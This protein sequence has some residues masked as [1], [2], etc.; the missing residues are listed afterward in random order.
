MRLLI[1]Y[2]TL[3]FFHRYILISWGIYDI[4]VNAMPD[5]TDEMEKT[6]EAQRS[7]LLKLKKRLAIME[8]KVTSMVTIFQVFQ[9]V[10]GLLIILI[11]LYFILTNI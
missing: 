1:L 4:K 9:I 2:K 6:L 11:L 7:N 5:D 3:Y 8:E 10:V